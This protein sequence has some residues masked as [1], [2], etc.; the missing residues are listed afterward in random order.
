MLKTLIC[1]LILFFI[2]CRANSNFAS[3]LLLYVC[4]S[5]AELSCKFCGQIYFQKA[6][7]MEQS[8]ADLKT[9]HLNI[10]LSLP[11]S[12]SSQDSTMSGWLTELQVWL[13]MGLRSSH[14][15]SWQ[16]VWVYILAFKTDQLVLNL[17]RLVF[18]AGSL[19]L[20]HGKCPHIPDD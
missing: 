11:G 7:P 20:T 13:Q 18:R 10:S 16:S 6:N 2:F 5:G 9:M 8:E 4:S 17:C 15:V 19:T 1:Y 12:F 14:L 3:S